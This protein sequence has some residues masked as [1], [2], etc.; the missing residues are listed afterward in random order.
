[1]QNNLPGFDDGDCTPPPSRKASGTAPHAKSRSGR[2]GA[3][4]GL[5]KEHH[6][7]LEPKNLHQMTRIQEGKHLHLSGLTLN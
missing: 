5:S 3:N 7:R 1:M 4:S 6:N 2:P